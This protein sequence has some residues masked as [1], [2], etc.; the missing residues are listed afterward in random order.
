[1]QRIPVGLG[2]DGDRLDAHPAGGLDDPAG[3]LAAIGDQNSFEHC[4]LLANLWARWALWAAARIWHAGLDIGNSVVQQN[5]PEATAVLALN[6]R[7]GGT[8]SPKAQVRPA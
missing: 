7:F 6:C 2:I 8:D 5:R 4:C 1:M 3:D